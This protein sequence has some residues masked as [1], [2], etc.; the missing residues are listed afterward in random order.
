MVLLIAGRQLLELDII[1]GYWNGQR[2]LKDR[3]IYGFIL[4]QFPEILFFKI[5][6]HEFYLDHF[7]LKSRPPFN[8][9]PL[10][11]EIT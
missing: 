2:D 10:S 8:F 1:L 7:S 5:G 11:K 9:D 4:F 3:S 6:Y